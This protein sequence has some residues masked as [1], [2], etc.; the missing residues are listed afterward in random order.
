MLTLEKAKKAIEASEK[1][2]AELGIKVTT[3]VID[4]NGILIS[5][6]RMDGAVAVSPD[7][8]YAKAYTAG[9]LGLPTEEIAKYSG[10]DK[11]YYGFTDIKPRRFTTIAGGLPVVEKSK[12]IGGVG[13]GGSYDVKEDAECANAAVESL[14]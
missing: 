13:V 10:P 14:K 3:V 9:T 8:A 7:F 12:L 4:N 2:A 1:K 6:S 11:P 5:A